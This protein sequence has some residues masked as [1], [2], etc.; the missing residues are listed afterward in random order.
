M[1]AMFVPCIRQYCPWLGLPSVRISSGQ[2]GNLLHC[3]TRNYY[4]VIIV[5]IHFFTYIILNNNRST[6]ILAVITILVDNEVSQPLVK[7]GTVDFYFSSPPTLKRSH[8]FAAKIFLW[9][10]SFYRQLMER[11]R[12]HSYPFPS[13][14]LTFR[15]PRMISYTWQ[16]FV[17][18]AN[19][20][21]RSSGVWPA[22]DKVH[23]QFKTVNSG[24]N[25]C[26]AMFLVFRWVR[27]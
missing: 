9:S 7:I 21:K 20:W 25:K 26:F 15:S 16:T 5:A 22:L 24:Q 6:A 18:N 10:F 12:S 8:S 13:S 11:V 23:F 17:G 1:F 4:S 2:F 14:K 19:E 27:G 3:G